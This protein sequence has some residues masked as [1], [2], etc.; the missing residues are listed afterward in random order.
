MATEQAGRLLAE[1]LRGAGANAE[2][3][4]RVEQHR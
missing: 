3:R 2:L 1:T 4:T